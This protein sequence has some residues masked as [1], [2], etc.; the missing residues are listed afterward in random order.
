MKKTA[1]ITGI[2]GQDGK[3]LC[4][5]LKKMNYN[6]YGVDVQGYSNKE[7]KYHG[8][9]TI[10]QVDISRVRLIH[11]IINQVKPDEI[12]NLAAVHR[13][14]HQDKKLSPES[15]KAI[16]AVSTVNMLRTCAMNLPNVKFFQAGSSEMFGNSFDDD[17]LQRTTTTMNPITEYGKTKCMAYDAVVEHRNKYGLFACNGILYNHESPYRK[18][19]FVT[20]KI[21][22]TAI[23]IKKGLENELRLSNLEAGRDW[24]HAKDYVRAMH[25]ILTHGNPSD[26][27]I[28]TGQ[29]S[30]I[31]EV[32]RHVFDKL[33]LNYEQYVVEDVNLSRN[34]YK[35]IPCGDPS[36]TEKELKWEREY[37]LYKMLDEILE[38]W[39]ERI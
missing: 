32:C 21:I 35:R 10:Y 17:G 31:R 30:T 13:I 14:E 9:S 36:I 1:L 5:Y 20:T 33:G 3:Y 16:N 4:E 15:M 24:G 37:D 28:S 34:E 26:W 38:Y 23:K 25:S 11:D 39:L 22:K 29:A 12:Y 27:I 18:E 19:K 2:T 8:I 6:V 7:L